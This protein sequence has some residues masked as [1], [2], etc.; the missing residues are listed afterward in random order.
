MT[1][2]TVWLVDIG[3]VVKVGSQRFKLD[4][5]AA[6]RWLEQRYGPVSTFLFNGFDPVYDIPAGLKAFYSAMKA[7]GMTVCLHPMSGRPGYGDH[8]QRRV[9][10]DMTAHMIWQASLTDV[11]RIVLTTG[12]QDFLP[13]VQI[14]RE[15]CGKQM[16]LLC[17]DQDV[18]N[19]LKLSMDEVI[20]L[21]AI[22]P[23]VER[24]LRQ[25]SGLGEDNEAEPGVKDPD[26]TPWNAARGTQNPDS[27]PWNAA[28]GTQDPDSGHWNEEPGS[29]T[30]E[31]S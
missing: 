2:R 14:A 8:R 24:G 18:S 9:D 1:L 21:D 17:Y 4:Y 15:H 11:E 12:D 23:H 10:V 30:R 19:E 13:A 7:H 27:T 16:V 31:A 28:R 3:F 6:A 20:Y 25:E 29:S 26:S 22:R 5:V